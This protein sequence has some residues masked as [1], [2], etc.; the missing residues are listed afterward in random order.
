MICDNLQYIRDRINRTAR[1]CGRDPDTIRLVAV[2]K[3][4]EVEKILQAADCGQLLFGENYLQEAREKIAAVDG[5]LLWHFIGHLQ[6]NKARQAAGLFDMVETVDRFKIAA[7][8]SRYSLELG[9]RLDILIQVNIGRERSKSG[10]SPEKTADLLAQ[11]NPLAGIRVRG[12]MT[13]PPYTSDPEDSRKF[14][15][16]LRRLAEELSARGLLGRETGVEL[17]MGMSRDFVIAIEEGATLVRVGTA[18]F[19]ERS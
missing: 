15:A 11:V 3:R 18:I 6:S 5:K 13:M 7:A 16:R 1:R 10:V 8:L 17:S 2:S 9:K 14:F 4:M 19:G 12:L